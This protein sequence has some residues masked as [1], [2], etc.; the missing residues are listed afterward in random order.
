MLITKEQN[1]VLFGQLKQ[2]ITHALPDNTKLLVDPSFS[3]NDTAIDKHVVCPIPD[4]IEKPTPLNIIFVSRI[5]CV[6][7]VLILHFILHF[8]IKQ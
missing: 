4:V 5:I 1:Y 3:D 8:L 7:I 2:K 6:S